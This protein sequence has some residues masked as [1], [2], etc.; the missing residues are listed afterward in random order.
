MTGHFRMVDFFLCLLP[1]PQGRDLD[2]GRLSQACSRGDEHISVHALPLIC[3]SP[4]G[5]LHLRRE[6]VYFFVMLLL[7]FEGEIDSIWASEDCYF[8]CTKAL[9]HGMM[10]G[11]QLQQ[12]LTA[13]KLAGS[14]VVAVDTARMAGW[15]QHCDPACC[16]KGL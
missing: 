5:L 7:Y 4:A 10:Q 2:V 1:E 12:W 3:P 14:D 6:P 11:K 13:H 8:P 15:R 9:P 16:V